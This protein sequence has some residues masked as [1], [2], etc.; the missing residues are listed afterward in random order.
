MGATSYLGKPTPGSM[1]AS[2]SQTLKNCAA[3]CQV[4]ACKGP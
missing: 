1:D 4:S 3:E 2:D